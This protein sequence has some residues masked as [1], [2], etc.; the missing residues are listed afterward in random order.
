MALMNGGVIVRAELFE[1]GSDDAF[2][3]QMELTKEERAML[4]GRDIGII[5]VAVSKEKTSD[6]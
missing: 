5:V 4:A 2:Q 3:L 1:I 6:E